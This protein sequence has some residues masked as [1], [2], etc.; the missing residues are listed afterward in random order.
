MSLAPTCIAA[1]A[2]LG[3][4]FATVPTSRPFV[5]TS[6]QAVPSHWYLYGIVFYPP[7][8]Y[9]SSCVAA[10]SRPRCR[11]FSSLVSSAQWDDRV[12]FS[13]EAIMNIVTS[14]VAMDSS[15][16]LALSQTIV[17]GICPLETLD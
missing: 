7:E 6:V 16:A 12:P 2:P 4:G 13:G 9:A 5:I 11:R 3:A 14:W 1:P 15:F 8:C 17:A 10:R